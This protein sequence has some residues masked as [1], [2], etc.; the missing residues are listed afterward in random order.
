MSRF[1]WL[2]LAFACAAFT[3]GN[4]AVPIAAW[5]A[6]VFLLRF[7]RSS[8]PL[9]GL[10]LGAV[11]FIAGQDLAW[12]GAI[13]FQGPTYH[14]VVAAIGLL[15]FLPV[16]ADRLIAPR[17][18]GFA[19]TLVFPCALVATEFA[20][21]SSGLGSWGLAAY[22]QWG[23]LPLLQVLSITG[24]WGVSFLVGWGASTANFVWARGWADPAA[25]RAGLAAAAVIA[26]VL[27]GGGLRL[28]LDPPKGPTVRVAGVVAENLD[29]FM[30][31]WAPLAQG[32]KLT[33]EVVEKARPAT[34]ELQRRL[35][36][37]SRE[38]A[39][40]GAKIVVW[41]EANALVFADDEAAFVAQ[42]RRLAR[43]EG[44]YLFMAMATITPGER[45]AQNKVVA[46]DASGAVRSTYLKSH[47]T[48]AEASVPGDGQMQVMDTPYGRLAW[49]ICYDFDYPALIRQAGRAGAD[50]LL[51]PS[52][53]SRGM[54][55]M[56]TH[57]AGLRA[58][59]NGAS[60][61]RVTND[62]L[63]QAVDA[64]GRVLAAMDDY[65]TKDR[66]KTMVAD[67]PVRGAVTPYARLGDWLAWGCV[68]G[69]ASLAAAAFARGKGGVR[70]PAA[71]TVG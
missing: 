66:V 32:R 10:A 52:W 31:A 43:E 49:A 58:V 25:R 2:A 20:W 17:L 65:G 29:V 57:M 18:K 51:N 62:G 3:V 39:R 14:A 38:E 45:Q 8:A 68:A 56:H 69:F 28:A 7:T 53:D 59:E 9:P 15:F 16:V 35:L 55:P 30:G 37:R 47:P 40:A 44:V 4:T 5:L 1:V 71:A 42:G 61:F 12:R 22:S 21:S 19:S 46:I 27:A 34:Q 50:I 60:M 24:L 26:A 36:D 67:L 33:P 63:S 23:A 48:P 13:V 54:D 41:S 6:P 11:A 64:Q 70:S